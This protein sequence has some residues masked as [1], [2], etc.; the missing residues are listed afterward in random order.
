MGQNG[1]TQG[2][3]LEFDKI[4]PRNTKRSTTFEQEELTLK[5]ISN[6]SIT[7]K[8]LTYKQQVQKPT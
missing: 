6:I 1:S 4:C 7:K 5:L 8:I 3:S 2:L